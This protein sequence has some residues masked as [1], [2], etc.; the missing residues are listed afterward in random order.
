MGGIILEM[1][2][3]SQVRIYRRYIYK[4]QIC[5][6]Y[7]YNVIRMISCNTII[8]DIVKN[9]YFCGEY[10][11]EISFVVLYQYKFIIKI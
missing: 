2:I 9:S 3:S 1:K 11:N 7:Q 8:Y 10:I 6:T 5:N 4:I